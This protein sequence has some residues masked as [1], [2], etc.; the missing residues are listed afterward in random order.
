MKPNAVLI[1]TS[2]GGIV[3]E[4]DLYDA[5]VNKIILGAAIDVFEKEP[6]SGNLAELDNCLLSCHMGSMTNDCRTRMEIEATED[7]IRYIL[8]EPLLQEVP[9]D[10]YD[11]QL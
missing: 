2:R 1:N 8:G 5:L 3:N 6:Y 4:Q 10:E 7:A 9:Q 11:N